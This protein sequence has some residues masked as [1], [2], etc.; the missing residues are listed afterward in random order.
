MSSALVQGK[1]LHTRTP[2]RVEAHGR[3]HTSSTLKVLGW[4]REGV[5]HPAPVS[6]PPRFGL[7]LTDEKNKPRL[8]M[9]SPKVT[10]PESTPP[11]PLPEKH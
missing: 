2:S 1:P 5:T 4:I 3:S 8:W 11:R 9:D 10:N 7:F 6:P